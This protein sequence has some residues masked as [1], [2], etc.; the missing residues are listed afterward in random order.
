MTLHRRLRHVARQ[1]RAGEN[2]ISESL[3]KPFAN[4]PEV[5]EGVMLIECD[6]G[7]VEAPIQR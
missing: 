5:R 6:E 3:F 2:K 1:L 7:R 4:A